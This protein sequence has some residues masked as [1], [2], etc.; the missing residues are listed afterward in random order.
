MYDDRVVLGYL[1]TLKA[2]FGNMTDPGF[3]EEVLL[4]FLRDHPRELGN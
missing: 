4:N 1:T 3:L 2:P